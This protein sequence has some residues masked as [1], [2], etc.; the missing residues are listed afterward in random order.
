MAASCGMACKPLTSPSPWGSL[1]LCPSCRSPLLSCAAGAFELWLQSMPAIHAAT[2]VSQAA[3]VSRSTASFFLVGTEQVSVDYDFWLRL[4]SSRA[5]QREVCF[6]FP[7]DL[8]LVMS[9][10][11]L[12]ALHAGQAWFAVLQEKVISQSKSAMHNCQSIS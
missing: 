11:Q 8:C 10:R 9:C 1:G 7:V 2:A 3:S 4:L 12:W 6:I 5:R